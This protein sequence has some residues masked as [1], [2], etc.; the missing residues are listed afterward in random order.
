MAFRPPSFHEIKE[1]AAGDYFAA[2]KAYALRLRTFYDSRA[3]WHRR[4]YRFSGIMIILGGSS[5]PV[6]STR[7]VAAK[8]LVVS[9]IGVAIAALTALRSFYRWDESWVLLRKTEIE[10]SEIYFIWKAKY[11]QAFASSGEL[12]PELYRMTEEMVTALMKTRR[13]EANSFFRNLSFPARS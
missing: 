1:I 7:N 13:D 2:A 9:L 4:F 10:I 6:I 3:R 8:D 12:S 5:L 11:D